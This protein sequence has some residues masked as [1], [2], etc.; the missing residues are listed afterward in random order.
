MKTFRGFHV[1]VFTYRAKNENAEL[2]EGFQNMP[3]GNLDF[4]KV[5]KRASKFTQMHRTNF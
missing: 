1:F 4:I 2:A 5:K 3:H